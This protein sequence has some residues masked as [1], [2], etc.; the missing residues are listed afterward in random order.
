MS[1]LRPPC[2]AAVPAALLVLLAGCAMGPPPLPE[3][4]AL[5]TAAPLSQ[6]LAEASQTPAFPDIQWWRRY[7]DATLD[8]PDGIGAPTAVVQ[9]GERIA[10]AADIHTLPEFARYPGMS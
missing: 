5:S 3:Q 6:P 8:E 7:G 4:G 1:R 2:R 9:T 10:W